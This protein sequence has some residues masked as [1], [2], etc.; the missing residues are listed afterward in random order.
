MWPDVVLNRTPDKASW[1]SL[2]K[3]DFEHF[4]LFLKKKKQDQGNPTL[5][6]L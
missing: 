4:F 5:M 2:D 6:G 3:E 1:K